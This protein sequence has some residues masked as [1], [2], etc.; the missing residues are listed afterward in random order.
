MDEHQYHKELTLWLRSSLCPPCGGCMSLQAKPE[1]L[2]THQHET[3]PTGCRSKFDPAVSEHVTRP[4]APSDDDLDAPVHQQTII[5]SV[6]ASTVVS[7]G[8]QGACL[9][10]SALEVADEGTAQQWPPLPLAG[11]VLAP[12][13]E[14]KALVPA[15]VRPTLQAG[16]GSLGETPKAAAA[17][18]AAA[19]TATS[20][21]K[22]ELNS[23]RTATQEEQLEAQAM[24]SEDVAAWFQRE[25]DRR[26]HQEYVRAELGTGTE[27]HERLGRIIVKAKLTCKDSTG[28]DTAL[29]NGL[30]ELHLHER[31]VDAARHF[32]QEAN[33][34][35]SNLVHQYLDPL[36][37]WLQRQVQNAPFEMSW[38][39]YE[40]SG[41]DLNEIERA[42]RLDR[43]ESRGVSP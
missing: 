41:V 36:T 12:R 42:E 19:P 18:A 28:V 32:L 1:E 9:A 39:P 30:L 22:A 34:L 35:K 5:S 3:L 16:P 26:L 23:P 2:T 24:Q 10:C 27:P 20:A 38:K 11:Q 31:E 13:P 4:C 7:R 33:G 8:C 43:M 6:G 15:A 40:I 37:R 14:A 21:V 29:E 17:A 25:V